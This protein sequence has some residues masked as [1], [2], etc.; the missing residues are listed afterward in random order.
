MTIEHQIIQRLGAGPIS[1]ADLDDIN[2]DDLAITLK[3]ML[4]RRQIYVRHGH[5]ALFWHRHTIP[6]LPT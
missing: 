4:E 2:S 6:P 1:L 3:F 5:V